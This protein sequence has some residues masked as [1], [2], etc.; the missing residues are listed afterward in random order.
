MSST[1]FAGPTDVVNL[2]FA[3]EDYPYEQDDPPARPRQML[4]GRVV[5]IDAIGIVLASNGDNIM[6]SF[7]DGRDELTLPNRG[8]LFPWAG[9]KRVAFVATGAEYEHKW[10]VHRA[11]ETVFMDANDM[12]LPESDSEYR[13][14]AR[15]QDDGDLRR[16][17][18]AA[19]DAETP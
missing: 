19:Y 6:P 2:S 7:N 8:D 12:R 13:N 4:Q 3:V 10:R 14:W 15:E 16:R 11:K 9:I 17:I 1:T 5:S 18:Q